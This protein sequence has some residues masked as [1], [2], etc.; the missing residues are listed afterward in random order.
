MIDFNRTGLIFRNQTD[1]LTVVE[2]AI[3]N[4]WTVG[5]LFLDASGGTNVPPQQA[6]NSTFSNNDISATG[7]ARSWIGNGRLGARPGTNV[8]NF[9]GN[10]WGTT[11]P[12]VTVANSNQPD[13][14]PARSLWPT[15]VRRYL[16]A[17]NRIS[18]DLHRPTSITSRCSAP[19]PTPTSKPHQAAAPLGSG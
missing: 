16:Q 2:N 12:V 3:T 1:N 4:N 14:T 6:L 13:A 19:G 10:W 8:K 11:T 17:A 15:A 7:M 5:I 18:R 9:S